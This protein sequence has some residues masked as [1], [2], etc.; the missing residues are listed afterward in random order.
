MAYNKARIVS[1]NENLVGDTALVKVEILEELTNFDRIVDT[2]LIT[3][4]NYSTF[5]RDTLLA[6]V[7]NVYNA[8]ATGG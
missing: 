4:S 2:I 5:T 8:W 3:I 1:V 6:E 7:L